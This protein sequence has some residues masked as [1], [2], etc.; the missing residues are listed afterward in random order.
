MP[1]ELYLTTK[2]ITKIRNVFPTNMS[3]D[4]KLSKT[5][6]GKIIQS[7]GSFVSSLGNL[8]RK[9]LT[10]IA[11]PLAGIS[12]QLVIGNSW[13]SNQLV[14]SNAGKKFK[15]NISGKGAVRAEKGFFF[16]FFFFDEDVN[17][18]VKMIKSLEY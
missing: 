10:N 12:N 1:Y 8:G 4:I 13:I 16:F 9:V 11:I 15:R 17:D 18:I 5:Q 6:I 7:G 3:T 2:Q 14:S